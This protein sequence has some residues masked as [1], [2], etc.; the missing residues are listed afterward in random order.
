MGK[1]LTDA[2]VAGRGGPDHG[3]VTQR[4]VGASG[5]RHATQARTSAWISSSDP[6]AQ[7]HPSTSVG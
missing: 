2:P 6:A 3:P 5:D 1:H 4:Q 7:E